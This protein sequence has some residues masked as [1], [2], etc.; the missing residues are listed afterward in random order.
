[1]RM[2]TE[3]EHLLVAFA[4]GIFGLALVQA[5]LAEWRRQ[6]DSRAEGRKTGV[7]SPA[8]ETVVLEPPEPPV[9]G[10]FYLLDHEAPYLTYAEVTELFERRGYA[11]VRYYVW[12]DDE[13]PPREGSFRMSTEMEIERFHRLYKKRAT[14][15]G[16]PY[17]EEGSGR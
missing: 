4:A 7:E 17:V 15:T 8:T 5:A 14:S 10:A 6:R 2:S 1:M 9:V 11:L 13:L 3:F 16:A 12:R